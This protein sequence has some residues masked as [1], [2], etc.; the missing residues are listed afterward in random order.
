MGVKGSCLCGEVRFEMTGPPLG[1]NHCHCSRCRKARGTANATNL[2]LRI[3]GFAYLSG[4]ELLTEYK[5]KGAVR[6]THA[7]CKVCGA[8]MPRIDRAL[9]IAIIPMG[10]F[11]DD[12]GIRPQ[13]HIFV[14]SKAAWD[15]IH[16]DL[17][18]FTE[19]PPPLF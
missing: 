13:R 8:S 2:F 18:Q 7:F 9:G 12:P 17:P 15:E 4:T 5:P 16:D 10:A 19:A 11:D 1:V 3:D 6:F 14:S